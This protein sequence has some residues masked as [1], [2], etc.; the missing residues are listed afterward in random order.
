M[1]SVN[2]GPYHAGLQPYHDL[3]IPEPKEEEECE[4]GR[5]GNVEE[6]WVPYTAIGIMMVVLVYNSIT[7]WT[8]SPAKVIL[9]Y[10][11]FKQLLSIKLLLL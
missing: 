7:S 1:I 6:R 2:L 4:A 10:C 3:E 9:E 5:G 8:S 11:C